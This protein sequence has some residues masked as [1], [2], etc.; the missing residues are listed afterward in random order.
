MI[1]INQRESMTLAKAT[2]ILCKWIKVP[3][4]TALYEKPGFTADD[5]SNVKCCCLNTVSFQGAINLSHVVSMT[6]STHVFSSSALL[7]ENSSD[8]L[9]NI[10]LRVQLQC[11]WS[12]EDVS[13]L[14]YDQTKLCFLFYCSSKI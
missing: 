10:K 1:L 2:K 14:T 3:D 12:L 6:C 9:P 13:L 4:S 8:Q 5:G 7:P 11:N